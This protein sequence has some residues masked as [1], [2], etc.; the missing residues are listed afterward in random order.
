MSTQLATYQS[1]LFGGLTEQDAKTIHET[2]AK[3]CNES[4]FRLFMAIAKAADANPV[5]G[6]IHPTVYQGKLTTQFGIDYHV[7]KAK[8]NEGYLGYDV[9]LI[10]EKDEFEM[11]QERSNDGRYYAVIDVHKW[12]MPRGRVVGGYAIA[13][14]D[15]LAP[16][17]V[18]MEVDEVDHYKKSDIGM[19]KRMWTNNF[20]DMFKKHMVKRALKAAFGSKF[21]EEE[22]VGVADVGPFERKDIT[23][24]ANALN[25]QQT[26]PSPSQATSTRTTPT[27]EGIKPLGDDPAPSP[28]PVDPDAEAIATIRVEVAAAFEKLG[29][30][31][32]E[33]RAAYLKKNAKVKGESPTLA[34][35]KALLKVMNLEIEA[36]ADAETLP[37][38]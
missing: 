8:E 25:Q 7:K 27:D 13:Y 2:I 26:K 34:E 15:G 35:Y 16:F 4:Q 24:E 29:I 6:E 17:T 22:E 11:H 33:A 3:D 32:K 10:H 36:A 21:N 9:Q 30:N 14:K 20:N 18:I 31:G 37:G 5:L 23:A 12:G 38:L 28:E 1:S 19:Q